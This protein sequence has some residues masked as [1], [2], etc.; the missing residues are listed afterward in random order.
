MYSALS[1]QASREWKRGVKEEKTW[2]FILFAEMVVLKTE[3]KVHHIFSTIWRF[4]RALPK[5]T[6]TYSQI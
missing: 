4:F 6:A 2:R 1:Q 3:P 5:R